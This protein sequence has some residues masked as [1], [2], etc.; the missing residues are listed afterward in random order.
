MFIIYWLHCLFKINLIFLKGGTCDKCKG[1]IE[2]MMCQIGTQVNSD[3]TSNE[4][5]ATQT[6]LAVSCSQLEKNNQNVEM[7]QICPFCG[8]IY[9][10]TAFDLFYEHVVTHI[11]S[12][13]KNR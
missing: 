5:E 7:D 13:N 4:N 11:L 9:N 2:K 12:D 6:S 10:K 1:K 3:G 8:D